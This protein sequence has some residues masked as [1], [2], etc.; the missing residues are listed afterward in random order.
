MP[1]RFLH[2]RNSL[3]LP[4]P[5]PGGNIED[6]RQFFVQRKDNEDD[7]NAFIL[8]VGWLLGTL[9]PAGPYP[10]LGLGGPPGSGKTTLLRQLRRLVDPHRA[11]AR[12]A[13]RTERDL[14]ISAVRSHIQSYDNLSRISRSLSDAM[15]R[16]STGGGLATRMLYSDD[17]EIIF[18]ACK[19]LLLASIKEVIVRPD[20]ADR[21]LTPILP[22][23]IGA[24]RRP[25]NEVEDEFVAAAPRI[26]GALLTAVSTGLGR[27]GSMEL[28]GDLPRMAAFA[29]WV[30]AS[31]PGF[32]WKEGTFREAYDANLLTVAN[33]VVEADP[34]AEAIIKWAES[35]PED[36]SV[37]TGYAGEALKLIGGIAGA[38][39]QERKD[40]PRS[41]RGL[42]HRFRTLAPVLQKFGIKLEILEHNH[43]RAKW[44][45]SLEES[46]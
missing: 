7:R 22:L 16:M 46:P 9:H 18:E 1:V 12:S 17:E 2:S 8:I 30:A 40:W 34:V 4:I 10:G 35:F 27:L 39:V 3:P 42:G 15:C 26:L 28:P 33:T 5:E 41:A 19:P 29:A 11:M 13:P 21:F 24:D 32:G 23:R 38:K 43:G 25:D 45:I 31:E 14:L 37:W 20:L 36:A 6:L 44:T